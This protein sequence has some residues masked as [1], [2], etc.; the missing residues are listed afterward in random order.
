M[1]EKAI[2]SWLDIAPA[3]ISFILKFIRDPRRAFAKVK[4]SSE[5]SPD[6]T[7]ILLGGIALSYLIVIVGGPPDLKQDPGTIAKLLR[8]LDYQ[9]LPVLGLFVIFAC[10]VVG[11][12][13][14][15]LYAVLVTIGKK[16]PAGKL[17]P[18]LGGSIEDSVNATL[19][20]SAVYIP[21][22]VAAITGVSR[23]PKDHVIEFGFA[24]VA[25]MVFPLI[26][27]P[28]ALSSTHR[29][30][31]WLQ[32]ALAVGGGIV[33]AVLSLWLWGK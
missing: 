13:L 26:Y 20:F 7:S 14:G 5:I 30:T 16:T 1:D 9:L 25:L 33:L 8:D 29:Q 27:F 2:K 17:D 21:L 22:A 31:T 19:G 3:Y 32:A 28:W 12:A 6:L 18:K 10:G 15:R 24:V 23:V 11:H 4:G